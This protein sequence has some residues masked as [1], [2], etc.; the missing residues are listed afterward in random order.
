[1][2]ITV[3]ELLQL[4]AMRGAELIAGQGGLDRIITSVNIMEVPEITRYIKGN[5]LLLTTTYPIKDDI[6]AQRRLIIDLHREGVA[7]LAIKP[8]FYGNEVPAVMVELANELNIPLIRLPDDA[9]FNDILN[10]V[11]GEILNRQASILRR[12]EETHQALTAIVLA[13]GSLEEIAQMLATLQ[14]CPI[15]IHSANWQRLIFS[16][17][18]QI[19]EHV[20]GSTLQAMKELALGLNE[21]LMKMDALHA[22]DGH[23][24]VVRD[25]LTLAFRTHPVTVARETFAHLVVWLFL[26]DST[27]Y[28]ILA[29][30]QA[31]TVVALEIT[32]LRAV[33]TVEQRFRS[34]FIEDII[35][36]KIE[37]R[38]IAI[39]R[40]VSYGWDL[41]ASFIPV[42]LEIDE[43]RRFYHQPEPSPAQILRRLWNAVS[44]S[45]AVYA[46]GCIVV[47]RGTRILALLRATGS[48]GGQDAGQIIGGMAEMI[49]EEL[50]EQENVS[51]SFGVGRRIEDI[52]GLRTALN[53]ATAAL[54]IGQLINGPASVTSFDDLGFYRVLFANH[55]R[56]AMNQFSQDLLRPLLESDR[57]HNTD[58]IHT[59]E[60]VLKCNGNLRAASRELFVHYNTLRYRVS[61]IEEMT[62]LDLGSFQGMLNLQ[63]ALMIQRMNRHRSAE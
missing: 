60:I 21:N 26:P 53:Q 38:S 16:V 31:S 61:R 58:F 45:T 8:I 23:Y 63:I 18:L 19:S 32:K 14:G 20:P 27:G 7:A 41:G 55:N 24:R 62:K 30:E 1:M 25:G 9:S 52:L 3:G 4:P 36:G 46:R 50:R 5:E 35:Q 56:D 51:V 49:N 59:L 48:V 40:G 22:A 33:A 13:G 57:S 11:L 37:S 42:L 12:N 47:D 29:M 10:P 2:K 43:F 39:S 28:D 17:P 6:K 44:V 34:Y 54:E 15:S